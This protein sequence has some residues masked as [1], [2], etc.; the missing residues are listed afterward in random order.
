MPQ[1]PMHEPKKSYSR[2]NIQNIPMG[3]TNL[4]MA[5]AADNNAGGRNQINNNHHQ[6][7]GFYNGNTNSHEIQLSPTTNKD[8]TRMILAVDKVKDYMISTQPNYNVQVGYIDARA[9]PM[10]TV[11]NNKMKRNNVKDQ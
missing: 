11:N 10:T 5:K 6:I 3:V 9:L 2:E 4:M 8:K 1:K 7:L